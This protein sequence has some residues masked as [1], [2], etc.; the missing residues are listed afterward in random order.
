M[1]TARASQE[2]AGASKRE[3]DQPI[4]IEMLPELDL[5]SEGWRKTEVT[6]GGVDTLALSQQTMMAETDSGRYFIGKAVAMTGWLGGYISGGPGP[7]GWRPDKPSEAP[8]SVL[9]RA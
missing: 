4:S 5:G 6:L 9:S 7:P 3:P 1:L 8:K 2:Q